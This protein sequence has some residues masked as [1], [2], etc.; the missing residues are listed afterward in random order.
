MEIRAVLFDVDNTLFDHHSSARDGLIAFLTGELS[1]QEER[2]ERL[3]QFFPLMGFPG[4]RTD[5]E[6]DAIFDVYLQKYE[7]AW[8]ALSP[9]A[10]MTS[11]SGKSRR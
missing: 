5:T 1:F 10:T 9:T 7:E 8:T 11:S 2:R 4:V 6:L 3:R